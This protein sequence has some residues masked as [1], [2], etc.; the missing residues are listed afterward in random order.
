[1]PIPRNERKALLGARRS[2]R[3][4]AMLVLICVMIFAFL[5]TV[6]FTV[7]IA[8]MHL[9]KSELRSATDAAAKAA[10]ETLSITGDPDEAIRVGQAIAFENLVAGEGLQLA[11][12]DF[13]FGQSLRVSNGKYVFDPSVT[14]FNSVQV[15]G[16]RTDSSLSGPVGLFFG[17]FFGKS[18]FSPRENAV[19]TFSNREIVVVV[20]R[21]GSMLGLKFAGLLQALELFISTV[22]T[23]VAEERVGL[24]SYSSAAT[25]DV[26]LSN[27]FSQFR[28][29]VARLVPA[30]FT[31]IG[32][33]IEAGTAIMQRGKSAS[34][35][36]K[37]LIIMTDG[38]HNT[39]PSPLIAAE[40]AVAQGFTIHTVTF[41]TD[42]DQ[43]TMK[44]IAEL[45][46]GVHLHA[47]NNAALI[48]AFKDLAN[49]LK[50]F[51]TE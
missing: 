29:G 51:L 5:V 19:A 24:A 9:T 50:T 16:E 42:A 13:T 12:S 2:S 32:S 22:E 33:G 4:G 21:S 35:T 48:Q 26:Q 44:R 45:G 7:D 40:A 37:T 10:A 20:D 28:A 43:N 41:G 39:G 17:R 18:Q 1:M 14:K 30:G 49:R 25:Q 8:Y 23:N 36:D 3:R 38:L 31:N 46:N 47:E 6:V 15:S 27:D 11:E 34:F